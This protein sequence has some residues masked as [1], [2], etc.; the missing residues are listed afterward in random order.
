MGGVGLV[1]AGGIRPVVRRRSGRMS[2]SLGDL[3][4]VD[5]YHSRGPVDPRAVLLTAVVARRTLP[6]VDLAV[7]CSGSGWDSKVFGDLSR[8]QVV[9]PLVEWNL[10]MIGVEKEAGR[11]VMLVSVV[12]ARVGTVDDLPALAVP[13]QLP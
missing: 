9:F 3:K 12:A 6:L 10:A 8:L 13:I 4:P 5:H 1:P 11:S 2:R 7:A